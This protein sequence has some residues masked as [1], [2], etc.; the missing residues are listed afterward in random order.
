MN[1]AMVILHVFSTACLMV[2]FV[3]IYLLSCVI[4]LIIILLINTKLNIANRSFS[5]T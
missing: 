2:E 5:V 1:G 4:K 3:Q